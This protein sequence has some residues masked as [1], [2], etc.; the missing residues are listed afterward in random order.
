MYKKLSFFA[1]YCEN[2]TRKDF[3]IM[4]TQKD[5]EETRKRYI[6][7]SANPNNARLKQMCNET[8]KILLSDPIFKLLF[9]A[10]LEDREREM[11]KKLLCQYFKQ[12]INLLHDCQEFPLPVNKC[13]EE[14]LLHE[15]IGDI[16]EINGQKYIQQEDGTLL[17]FEQAEKLYGESHQ[18]SVSQLDQ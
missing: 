8:K 11:L 6:K 16:I 9:V 13:E 17:T 1:I 14:N 4:T 7:N 18:C 2:K 10:Y 15:V 12:D 3:L 5:Y